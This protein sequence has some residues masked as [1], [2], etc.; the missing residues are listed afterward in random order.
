MGAPRRFQRQQS[1]HHR[2]SPQAGARTRRPRWR[3]LAQIENEERGIDG[4]VEDACGHRQPCLLVAPERTERPPHPHIETTFGGDGAR[5]LADHQ[6][7]RQAPD[8]RENQQNDQGADIS[9]P[10]QNIFNP[11]GAAGNHEEG[12][13]DERDQPQLGKPLLASPRRNL[14]KRDGDLSG[15]EG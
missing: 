10:A 12:G 15:F 3:K 13:G 6:G 4:H 1:A 2:Q 8:Q 11:I 5:E 9:G 14:S 7:C